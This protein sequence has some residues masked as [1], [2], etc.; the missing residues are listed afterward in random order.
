LNLAMKQRLVGTIVLGCLALIFIPLLLDGDGVQPV[1]LNQNLPAPPAVTSEPVPEPERPIVLS[2]TIDASTPA[3][4]LTGESNSLPVFSPE[5]PPVAEPILAEEGGAEQG[6]AVEDVNI[7]TGNIGEQTP[8]LPAFDAAGLPE[9]WSV[10]VGIF[11]EA[12]NAQTLLGNLLNQG[13]KAYTAPVKAGERSF[14]GVFVGPVIT[15]AEANSLKSELDARLN[16]NTLVS[17]YTT[18]SQE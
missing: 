9:A 2:D 3:E 4:T 6:V 16:E 8:Q 15:R 1:S 17:R 13:Y 7:E 10:R 11:G 12:G 5:S 18:G 14:T